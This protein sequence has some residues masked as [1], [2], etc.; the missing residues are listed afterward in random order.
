MKK[1]IRDHARDFA[2]IIVLAVIAL[3]VGGYILSEQ[4]LRFP[5]I[6]EKPLTLK[7]A[8]STAQAVTP[9]QGQTV[10]V[11]GVKVGDVGKVELKNGIAIVELQVLPKY[12]DLI[13][14]DAKLLLR[15]KTA[16]KDM[17]IEVM[18]VG[19][20][21]PAKSGFT[22][23]VENTDP[24]VNPDEI[25]AMLDDDTR[26]YLRLLLN[27]AAGGLRDRGDDLRE[28]FERFEPTHR[29]IAR[30]TT[31]VA[32]RREN[33]RRLITNLNR[34]NGELARKD[35]DLAQLVDSS[36]RVFRAFA[37][38]D[39]NI[40]LAVDRLPEALEQTTETLGKVERFA[41]ILGPAAERLRPA[42]R[43]LDEANR[44]LIPLAEEGTPILEKEIRP[45][46]REARPLV[47]DLRPTARRLATSTPDLTRSFV[48]LN[49]LFNMLGYNRDGREGPEVR[50]RDEGY[51]FWIAWLG[52]VGGAVFATSDN[53]GTLRPTAIQAN[54]QTIKASIAETPQLAFLQS[55]TGA[56]FDP[57]ICPEGVDGT[58]L[59]QLQ[60]QVLD[61]LPDL[62]A[63]R[64]AARR[65]AKR[66]GGR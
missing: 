42:A 8:F 10:R 66:G 47:G 45:F 35:D 31:K 56:L 58:L 37:S 27:G 54:C 17:F 30:I 16:L 9:G 29:D 65:V 53:G 44:S 41:R 2:A 34:L 43:R 63:R 11:S 26:D 3:G 12:R 18:D 1:A 32:E 24:D 6:E 38:Q 62:P 7:A 40:T 25:F 51:L 4:R 21:P 57:R 55:L 14:E 23:P 20:G 39:A 13:R 5:I 50:T 48:V 15:P 52:H 46:V 59:D 33:L 64:G 22:L 36:S 19:K 61:N 49:N 28:V 60:D